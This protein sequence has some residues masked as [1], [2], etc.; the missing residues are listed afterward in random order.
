MLRTLGFILTIPVLIGAITFTYLNQHESATTARAADDGTDIYLPLLQIGSAPAALP[1]LPFDPF[2]TRAG[3]ATMYDYNR[4]GNCTLDPLPPGTLLAAMNQADYNGSALCGA[5][6]EVIGARGTVQVVVA[7]RCPGCSSGDL[8]LNLPAFEELTGA[9]TGRFPIRWR[10][11]SPPLVG[12]IAYRFQ[13]SN[14]Y[15][16]KVQVLNHRN[17]IYSIEAR[18]PSGSWVQLTRLN[19]NFF[20]IPNN[21]I[22]EPYGTLTLR[23]TDIYGNTISDS[24]IAIVNDIKIPGIG[25]FPPAP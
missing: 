6:L 18:V 13:G 8:D 17:P 7:D 20:V 11:I 10:I 14:P 9:T 23:T 4:I 5:Y 2:A 1:S 21:A 3:D 16:A 22:P 19:D 12:P 25:Q 24:K 15:Y